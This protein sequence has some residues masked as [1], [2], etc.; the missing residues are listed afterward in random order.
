M[1]HPLPIFSQSDYL[2]Q[3]VDINSHTEWQ[4]VQIQIS[5]LLRSQLIWISIVCKG[6]VYPG[7]A[8]QGLNWMVLKVN[9]CIW[10]FFFLA[11]FTRETTIVTSCLLSCTLSPFWKGICSKRKAFA[12]IGCNCFPFRVDPSQNG[13]KHLCQELPPLKMY[14]FTL[15]CILTLVLLNSDIPCFCKHWRS[16]LI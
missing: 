6:R 16:H 5:W 10:Y 2:I 3:V 12:P 14:P 4:T 13:T 8:G 15:R 7:S 11:F 1:P 9:K